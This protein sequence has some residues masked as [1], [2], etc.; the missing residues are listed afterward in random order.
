MAQRVKNP[1]AIQETGDRSLIPGS[2]RSPRGRI[3]NPF[4][5]SFLKNPMDR[6]VWWTPR[7]KG[8]QTVGHDWAHMQTDRHTLIRYIIC[9]YFLLFIWLLFQF[10][11]G[12]PCSA[13]LLS[14]I[15]SHLCVFCFC[16][17][18]AFVASAFLFLLNFLAAMGLRC[19]T[20]LLL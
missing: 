3:G 18:F 8:S 6:G 16:F 4:Q 5:C 11:D 15:Q 20:W 2:E 9:K 10:V 1:P 7:S 19:S 17:F 13:K 14:L 12:F